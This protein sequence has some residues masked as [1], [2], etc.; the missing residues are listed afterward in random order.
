ME[1]SRFLGLAHGLLTT[2]VVLTWCVLPARGQILFFNDTLA[3]SAKVE[4]WPLGGDDSTTS[5]GDDSALEVSLAFNTRM[6]HSFLFY[7]QNELGMLQL[8]ISSRHRVRCRVVLANGGSESSDLHATLNSAVSALGVADGNEHAVKLRLSPS[9]NNTDLHLSLSLDS[10]AFGEA[11]LSGGWALM[12][13]AATEVYLG[14]LP[15][16]HT[17]R[18]SGALVAPRLLG[19]IHGYSVTVR[20]SGVGADS[21]EVTTIGR[22]PSSPIALL[23]SSAVDRRMSCPVCVDGGVSCSNGGQCRPNGVSYCHCAGTGFEGK[24]CEQESPVMRL[25]GGSCAH[26]KLDPLQPLQLAWRF[27]IRFRSN[28]TGTLLLTDS[29]HVRLSDTGSVHVRHTPAPHLSAVMGKGLLASGVEWHSVEITFTKDNT[30][31]VELDRAAVESIQLPSGNVASLRPPLITSFLALGCTPLMEDHFHGC[32]QDVYLGDLNLIGLSQSPKQRLATRI[33]VNMTGNIASSCPE[34]LHIPASQSLTVS[35]PLHR[36]SA[37][38][39]FMLPAPVEEELS[40]WFRTNEMDVG[41]LETTNSTLLVSLTIQCGNLVLG[42]QDSMHNITGEVTAAGGGVADGEWHRV[43]VQ[44]FWSHCTIKLHLDGSSH[45]LLVRS[46]PAMPCYHV[47]SSRKLLFSF[48]QVSDVSL[49]PYSG[50]IALFA[51][52]RTLIPLQDQLAAGMAGVSPGCM[53][54]GDGCRQNPCLNAGTCMQGWQRYECDCSTNQFTG[55]TCEEDTDII[56]FDEAPLAMKRD[57][58]FTC[59]TGIAPCSKQMLFSAHIRPHRLSS[60]IAS[61][62]WMTLTLDKGGITVNITSDRRKIVLAVDE[63]VTK[64]DTWY[65]VSV[66]I[67]QCRVTLQVDDQ[68]AVESLEPMEVI[69]PSMKS[70]TL[71]GYVQHGKQTDAASTVMSPYI[72]CMRKVTV[73]GEDVDSAAL[74]GLHIGK[75]CPPSTPLCSAGPSSSLLLPAVW[76]FPTLHSAAMQIDFDWQT[77]STHR[78]SLF[79]ATDQQSATILSSGSNNSSSSNSSRILV[80]LHR[81][82]VCLKVQS[83]GETSY[84]T[85][86]SRDNYTGGDYHTLQLTSP[87]PNTIVLKI[88][89]GETI[90]VMHSASMEGPAMFGNM[91]HIAGS[92][93]RDMNSPMEESDNPAPGFAGCIGNVTLGET[94]MDDLLH[95]STCSQRPRIATSPVSGTGRSKSLRNAVL[96]QCPSTADFCKISPCKHNGRCSSSK[97]GRTCSC[98]GTGHV[99]EL[100]EKVAASGTFNSTASS[101]GVFFAGKMALHTLHVLL[102]SVPP[103]G[104][105][106]R[107]VELIA[108]VD[109][110][111]RRGM[112]LYTSDMA[113]SITLVV[114][115]NTVHRCK[116]ALKKEKSAH[117]HAVHVRVHAHRSE[118]KLIIDGKET[119]CKVGTGLL[120]LRVSRVQAGR[121][122]T[123]M[124]H[125]DNAIGFRGWLKEIYVNNIRPLEILSNSTLE[126]RLLAMKTGVRIKTHQVTPKQISIPYQGADCSSDD[127]DFQGSGSGCGGDSSGVRVKPTLPGGGNQ[128]PGGGLGPGGNQGTSKGMVTATGQGTVVRPSVSTADVTEDCDKSL[129][130][131]CDGSDLETS[132]ESGGLSSGATV[133]I[134]IFSVVVGVVLGVAAVFV[135]AKLIGSQRGEFKLDEIPEQPKSPTTLYSPTDSGEHFL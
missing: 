121:L 2:L 125:I 24:H 122:P 37:S 3:A 86:C 12:M 59:S 31:R 70:I 118:V 63:R 69:C 81:G 109:H 29:L 120:N 18:H 98:T 85:N 82:R 115:T 55:K 66:S 43:S 99:G 48:G 39:L 52:D 83:L 111:G 45:V 25:D 106:T 56:T 92:F 33:Q 16:G 30:I 14:G 95:V 117:Q 132:G 50:C 19:C 108:A 44:L 68:Q 123:A 13:Q 71:G 127:E 110:S 97:F 134:I 9:G 4:S 40:F 6:S 36:M 91:V 10:M 88:L 8:V 20:R 116:A 77:I 23:G 104:K 58:C 75:S 124:R 105:H 27:H 67:L 130:T 32:L 61:S 90:R 87:S 128:G 60:T 78:I 65:R 11:H 49:K 34:P 129:D 102:T 57:L 93:C 38:G 41:V 101:L 21:N 79:F 76:P 103:G 113:G 89:S 131:D 15:P 54:P 22:L 96:Y 73:A 53:G 62:S 64:T 126:D 42:I 135:I 100:C 28:A 1:Q 112:W 51:V 74:T 119:V 26:F 47:G 5:T 17:P 7:A 107:P 133:G 114:R 84:R 94:C 72:G 35:Q 80:I 46:S